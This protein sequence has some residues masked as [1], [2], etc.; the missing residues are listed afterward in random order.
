MDRSNHHSTLGNAVYWDA[1]GAGRASARIARSRYAHLDQRIFNIGHAFLEILNLVV[2]K[3]R[4][5]VLLNLKTAVARDD[6]VA[7]LLQRAGGTRVLE[8]EFAC[9]ARKSAGDAKHGD[10]RELHIV[11]LEVSTSWQCFFT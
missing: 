5:S 4:D 2:K 8:S 10:H 6:I 9:R 7:I 1:V 3:K 11:K